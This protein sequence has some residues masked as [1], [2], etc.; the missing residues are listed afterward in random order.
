MF[1]TYTIGFLAATG[2]IVPLIVHLW[3]VKKGKT[4][5]IGSIILLGES[6]KQ[7]S[8][9]F[10]IKD[11]LLFLLR[12]LLIIIIAFLLAEPFLKINNAEKN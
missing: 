8:K 1:F 7:S 2:I 12:S 11:W 10:Q 6:A 5:K 4:L 3:N 9:S